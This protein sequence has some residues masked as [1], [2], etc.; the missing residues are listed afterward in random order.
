MINTC[1]KHVKLGHLGACSLKEN[2]ENICFEMTCGGY[3]F[4]VTD[5]HDQLAHET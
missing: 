2:F 4:I 3:F 5:L 1:V